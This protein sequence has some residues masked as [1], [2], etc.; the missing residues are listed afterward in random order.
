MPLAYTK[1]ITE[2][3]KTV[4]ICINSYEDQNATGVLYHSM[5]PQ[6]IE[7]RSLTQMLI[8]MEQILDKMDYPKASTE[9]RRFGS[10]AHSAEDE[11]SR[12]EED[13]PKGELA[14]FFVRMIFRQNASWQGSVIWSEGGYDES[15]RSALELIMLMDSALSAPRSRK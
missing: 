5:F 15:F 6:G 8:R 1:L 11:Q 9:K 13:M 14:T 4:Q 12:D 3:M 2:S 10:L 7:F